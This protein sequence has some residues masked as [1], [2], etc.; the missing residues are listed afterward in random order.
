MNPGGGAAAKN[1]NPCAGMQNL[2]C[3][4]IGVESINERPAEKWE[5][6][7]TAQRQ[8][9]KMVIWLDEERRI[10]IRQLLP[11]G[12]TME[13]RLVGRETLNGRN[14][15][16]WEMK[17]TRRGGQS[18]VTYQWFDHFPNPQLLYRHRIGIS[19]VSKNVI[20]FQYIHYQ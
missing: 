20:R 5:L 16:K 3:R 1:V 2:A 13:M 10:P 15:E 17:A 18:S 6:E 14:T 19:M 4:R 12:S 9:G 11:D 8:S 7:N